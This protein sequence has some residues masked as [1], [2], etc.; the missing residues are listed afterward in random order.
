MTVKSVKMAIG[1]IAA[2]SP[3]LA[4]AA[5]AQ[6]QNQSD[7]DRGYQAGRADAA[8]A[9]Q[10]AGQGY[11]QAPPPADYQ[12]PE[13]QD[14]R[15]QSDQDQAYPNQSYPNQAY[16]GQGAQT[17]QGQDYQAQGDN[18]DAN[19]APPPPADY[20]GSQLPPPR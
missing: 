17:Y 4:S 13:D 2:A 10:G 3:L 9:N 7:Y 15:G 20:D 1:L 5:A 11:D 14:E 12:G 6:T 16:Q 8:R 18:D 19:A